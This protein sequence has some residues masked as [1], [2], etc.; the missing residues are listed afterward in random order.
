VKQLRG[1]T[2]QKSTT[3][4]IKIIQELALNEAQVAFLMEKVRTA[5]DV[6]PNAPFAKEDVPVPYRRRCLK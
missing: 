5:Q 4:S 3:R 6:I 2:A 1:S